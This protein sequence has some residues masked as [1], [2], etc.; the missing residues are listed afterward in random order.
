MKNI[1]V[2]GLSILALVV[3]G[4]SMAACG[5]KS[6]VGS[7]AVTAKEYEYRSKFVPLNIDLSENKYITAKEIK[8]DTLYA[9]VV[10][11]EG[12]SEEDYKQ[13]VKLHLINTVSGEETVSDW[14]FDI[15]VDEYIPYFH[16]NSDNSFSLIVNQ[17]KD[18]K[19]VFSIVN[20]SDKGEALSKQDISKVL[21]D[22]N[23]TYISRALFLD[24]GNVVLIFDE[25]LALVSAEGNVL[26][27]ISLNGWA[28]QAFLDS[29]GNVYVGAY[30]R[31][32]GEHKTQKVDFEKGKLDEEVEG[33]PHD[34]KLIYG[35]DGKVYAFSGEG[36]YEYFPETKTNELLFNWLNV[37]IS[38]VYDEDIS[39]DENG[40]I[41]FVKETWSENSSKLEKISVEKVKLT[42]ENKIETLTLACRYID[43][44]V[45]ESIIDYNK[46][47]GKYRVEVV[48]YSDMY[49]D[50]E[51]SMEQMN[52]DIAAGKY[53]IFC[54]S[55]DFDKYA[56]NGA[57]EDLTP[58]FE[59]SFNEE[60]L[61]TNVVNSWRTDGKLYYF[62]NSFMLS[63]I[64]GKHDDLA[65]K[66][67]LSFDDLLELRK[68]YPDKGF[69][70][71]G[72]KENA[73]Y[74][75]LLSSMSSFVDSENGKCNFECEDFYKV[76]EFADTFPEKLRNEDSNDWQEILDGDIILVPSYISGIDNL[77]IYNDLFGGKMDIVGYPSN[78]GS[79]VTIIGNEYYAISSKCKNKDAAWE[80]IKGLVLD[81]DAEYYNGFPVVKKNFDEAMKR[82]MEIETYVDK[83]GK[84]QKSP[85]VTWGNGEITREYYGTTQETVDR[86]EKVIEKASTVMIVDEQIYVIISEEIE[87]FFKGQKSVEEAASIIQSR[88]NLYLAETR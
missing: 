27:S 56:K 48:S 31:N 82:E 2:K 11:S 71:Y 51:R 14:C 84:V 30:D 64:L 38:E 81:D 34:S 62:S 70:S 53:D 24:D 67:Q 21:E 8:G 17:Y 16:V 87:P 78:I 43:W 80:L 29:E 41:S 61:F 73:F 28:S 77:E 32:S 35:K 52:L 76:C 39:V 57:F 4:F 47:N 60:D 9:I 49:E 85:K 55:E 46:N 59:E 40:V 7:E 54:G 65:G 44:N 3:F 22:V 69:I 86:L 5:S 26:K 6:N 88:V 68:K 74:T 37:D 12:E 23:Q 15:G 36:F 42:D 79:G 83:N 10:S 19:S 75:A 72:T 1:L 66:E 13:V 18:D 45:K 58:Y 63:A 33:L 25:K 50:Y 20:Y